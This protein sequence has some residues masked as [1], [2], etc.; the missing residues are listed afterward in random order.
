MNQSAEKYADK[1]FISDILKPLLSKIE[2][3]KGSINKAYRIKCVYHIM[4]FCAKIDKQFYLSHLN[5]KACVLERT[6]IL[7]KELNE[8]T[9][10]PELHTITR[11][12]LLK[13]QKYLLSF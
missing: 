4:L 11:A 6:F 5:F 8:D 12:A 1:A 3:A 13:T 7:I 2:N 9:T 10:C